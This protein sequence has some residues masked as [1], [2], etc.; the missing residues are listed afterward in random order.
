MAGDGYAY[1]SQV[2]IHLIPRTA[3]RYRAWSPD[4]ITPIA[5]AEVADGGTFTFR[6]GVTREAVI[7][8]YALQVNGMSLGNRV[9]SVNMTLAV[10]EPSSALAG[11]WPNSCL[12]MQ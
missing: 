10:T 11:R 9:R 5:G 12:P 1:R 4:P 6:V 7:G 2:R 8:D 3:V